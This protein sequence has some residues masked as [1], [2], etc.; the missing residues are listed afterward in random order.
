MAPDLKEA[1][2]VFDNFLVVMDGQLDWLFSE[3]ERHGVELNLDLD[4]L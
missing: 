2:E 1:E 3:A 4:L